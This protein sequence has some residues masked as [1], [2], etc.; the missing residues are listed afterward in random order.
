[1]GRTVL[2]LAAI[3]GSTETF[4]AI[5]S[6]C[7]QRERGRQHEVQRQHRLEAALDAGELYRFLCTHRLHEDAPKAGGL[8]EEEMHKMLTAKDTVTGSTVLMAAALGGSARVFEF[9][10][11]LTERALI[12]DPNKVRQQLAETDSAGCSLL[13]L[14]AAS[15]KKSAVEAVMDACHKRWKLNANQM[16]KMLSGDNPTGTAR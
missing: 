7:R 6:A 3:G 9:A 13:H 10:L 16:L 5:A 12:R 8:T 1:M 11:Y 15:R 2:H 14:A 4:V